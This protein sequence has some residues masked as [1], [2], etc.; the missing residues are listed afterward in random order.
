MFD[1][2]IVDKTFLTECFEASSIWYMMYQLKRVIEGLTYE[3]DEAIANWNTPA[4]G[5]CERKLQ[6]VYANLDNLEEILKNKEVDL[7]ELSP[8][9]RLYLN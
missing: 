8:T 7:Y 3:R 2:E 1:T 4:A 6:F 5:E 9:G